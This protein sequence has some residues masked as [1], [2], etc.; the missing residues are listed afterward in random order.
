MSRGGRHQYRE[1]LHIVRRQ[2]RGTDAEGQ[3]D[4][5]ER[6]LAVEPARLE[7]ESNG[8]TIDIDVNDEL[9]RG[10][11]DAPLPSR[12]TTSLEEE[13]SQLSDEPS[14]IQLDYSTSRLGR[15]QRI[16]SNSDSGSSFQQSKATFGLSDL[17]SVPKQDSGGEL[18][19]S[20]DSLDDNSPNSWS[21]MRERHDNV[22]SPRSSVRGNASFVPHAN[23]KDDFPSNTRSGPAAI[24][25]GTQSRRQEQE[26]RQSFPPA[27]VQRR[28]LSSSW[29]STA[30]AKAAAA[31]EHR[32]AD[33]VSWHA[34]DAHGLNAKV[35]E[36]VSQN[37]P[38]PYDPV[39][40]R[41]YKKQRA[42]LAVAEKE[43]DY[44]RQELAQSQ[45]EAR[46]M[47]LRA[48]ARSRSSP[49]REKISCTTQ[50]EPPD[51]SKLISS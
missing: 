7:L 32:R 10:P 1:H 16:R 22:G 3:N 24:R 29:R 49:P 9:E 45:R 43:K 12:T 34:R 8:D 19:S 27:G 47:K 48:R 41:R 37:A 5:L 36:K 13:D 28:N 15:P 46:D 26:L 21:A 18:G 23:I 44:E 31:K 42:K 25:R 11:P 50:T 38:L 51:D 39:E 40:F 33:F 2:N 14:G 6:V 17:S 20:R 35:E 4:L 30:L